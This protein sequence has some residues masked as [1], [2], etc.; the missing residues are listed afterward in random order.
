VEPIVL[1]IALILALIPAK[2]AHNKGRSFYLWWLYGFLLLIIA[3]IHSL[4]IKDKTQIKNIE[5]KLNEK[6]K[7]IQ[8]TN[9]YQKEENDSKFIKMTNMR[10]ILQL[11]AGKYIY[12][13]RSGENAR[14]KEIISPWIYVRTEDGN[15]GWCLSHYI[16]KV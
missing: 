12:Y 15:E 6:Y 1:I 9:L 14:V 2:I 16:E 8:L 3:T 7:I 13:L 5:L 11:D 10:K 4:M